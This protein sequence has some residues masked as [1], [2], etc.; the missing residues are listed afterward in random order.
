MKKL[1][2]LVLAAGLVVSSFAGASAGEFKPTATLI[3]QY[4][5]GDAGD[6]TS[7]GNQFGTGV[8]FMA[9]LRMELGFDYIASENLSATFLMRFQEHYGATGMEFVGSESRNSGS[10]FDSS[11][12]GAL[13]VR[14]AYLDWMIPSTDVQVRMGYQP[15][16]LPAFAFG[17]AVLDSRG[18]GITVS[19]PIN[20]N[21]AVTAMWIRALTNTDNAYAPDHKPHGHDDADVFAVVGDFSYDGF[22][23]APWAM[24]M[25]SGSYTDYM[26]YKDSVLTEA[27]KAGV[28]DMSAYWIGASFELSM[29][30]PFTF[31]IDA[32]YND[33]DLNEAPGNVYDTTGAYFVGASVAYKTDMGTPAFK[34]WYASGNDIDGRNANHPEVGAPVT[35]SGAFGATSIMFDNQ[36]LDN[37]LGSIRSGNPS[38][39][40]GVVLEWADMSFIENLSHTARVAYIAGTNDYAQNAKTTL[41]DMGDDDSVVELNFNS[42]Y[43]IYKNLSTSL[44]IGYMFVDMDR[45]YSNDEDKDVFRSAL[46]FSYSF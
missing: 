35:L 26:G 9:S 36:V 22:R 33:V 39:T 40:W 14:L 24:Y 3:N 15:A 29:F 5:F 10:M 41:Q 45:H 17:S 18:G 38:G 2:T 32:F 11:M 19:A 6:N 31:A 46:S 12:T 16:S 27:I 4:E 30:D 7:A 44:E 25:M 43:Q 8:H 42:T 21:I 1:T 20:E 28:D 34:T 23:V 13:G 37:G